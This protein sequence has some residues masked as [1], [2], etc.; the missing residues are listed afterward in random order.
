MGICGLKSRLYRSLTKKQILSNKHVQ[1][2]TVVGFLP[3]LNSRLRF[4]FALEYLATG[5]FIES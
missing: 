2:K 4:N 1:L 3:Q 5:H